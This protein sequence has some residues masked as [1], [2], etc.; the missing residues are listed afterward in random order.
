M[1]RFAALGDSITVGM[2]DPVPGGGWRGWAAL[3]ASTL[4]QPELHNLAGSARW[5]PT[6]SAFSCRPP[7]PCGRT[8]PAWWSASTTRCAATS[9]RTDRCGRRPDGGRAAGGGRAGAHHAAA[10]PRADVRAA[11]GAGPAAGPADARGEHGRGRGGAAARDA[12]P[13]RGPGPRHLRAPVLERGPAA[14]ERARPP[15]HRLP[16]PRAAGHGRV[17]G[18]PRPRPGAVQPAADQAGRGPLDGHQ[19]HRLAG[20]AV[21][22]PGT[23]PGGAG[24]TGVARPARSGT[25]RAGKW[26]ESGSS[27]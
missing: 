18:R 23:R 10:R 19:G 2:G 9:T 14:P 8:W 3:L 11:G 25:G 22:G 7:R 16:L 20:P 4:P 1:T 12:A 21:P 17:R 24:G 27:P 6:W 15:P 5:R 13:G 26:T